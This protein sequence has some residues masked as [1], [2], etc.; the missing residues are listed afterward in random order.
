MNGTIKPA[1][2][3]ALLLAPL[4]ALHA[5]EF[6]VAPNGNDVNPGTVLHVSPTGDDANPGTADKPLRT[7]VAAQRAKAAEV[8]AGIE[9]LLAEGS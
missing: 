7:F 6:Y 8:L 4:A 3:T 1:L 9:G 5:A 2:L